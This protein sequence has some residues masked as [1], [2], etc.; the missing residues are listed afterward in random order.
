MIDDTKLRMLAATQRGLVTTEQARALGYSKKQRRRLF[1]GTRWERLMPR[2]ARLVGSP[3]TNEQHALAAVLDAGVGAALGGSSAAA[4]WGIPGNHLEPLQ[5]VRVRDR[6]NTPARSDQRHEPL[7]LPSA[8][9]VALD[10]VPTQVPARALFD[11]AGTR[12]RGAELPWFIERMERMVDNAWS[13]RLVSGVTL[14]AM[15]D[16]MASRGR[17]GIRVMR[18]VLATRGVDYEPPASNLEA[19]VSKI[20]ADGGLPEMRRQVNV[21]DE[22]GWIGRVD[23]HDVELPLIVE[24]QSERFHASLIDQQLDALRIQRLEQ[25]GFVVVEVT[26]VQVWHRPHEMLALVRDGR[27]RAAL[28]V[29]RGAERGR[30][31]LNR[32]AKGP[33]NGPF[34]TPVRRVGR[35]SGPCGAQARQAMST[36]SSANAAPWS[37]RAVG[38]RASE[39]ASAAPLASAP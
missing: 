1:D 6:A 22:K 21:G 9:V 20:L 8:H 24:V 15:L 7:L 19:R 2:V 14:H 16:E 37:S 10:G 3:V 28:R 38:S 23:L 18:D 30:E 5:I 31:I 27:R 33:R 11:I 25:A 36:S 34:R 13:A 39:A 26:D 32:G 4:W 17:P 29:R 12:R 35:G